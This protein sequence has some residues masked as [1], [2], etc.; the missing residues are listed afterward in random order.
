MSLFQPLQNFSFVLL[1]TSLFFFI[2]RFFFPTHSP[3]LFF[4]S[5]SV[6]FHLFFIFFFILPL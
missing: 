3:S 5:F 4:L 6:F 1:F 2:S